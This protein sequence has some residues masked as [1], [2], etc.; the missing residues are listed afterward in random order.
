MDTFLDAARLLLPEAS[1]SAMVSIGPF[2]H[3]AQCQL[4]YQKAKGLPVIITRARE[5]LIRFLRRADVVISMAGYNTISEIMRFRKK[6]IIIP[7]PGPSAEQ[8]MRSRIMSARGLFGTIHPRDLTA[9]KLA[10][11]VLQKLN[12]NEGMNEAM[13]PD[14]NGAANT[15][16]LLLSAI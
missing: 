1:F 9:E 14:L 7:R 5:E 13:V 8:T 11:L 16:S 2:M 3:E 10:G 6:A 15:A 12:G 4:I